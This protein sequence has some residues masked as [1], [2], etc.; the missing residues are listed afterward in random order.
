MTEPQA[1]ERPSRN[2]RSLL[3]PLS[4]FAAM[5]VLCIITIR[6][7]AWFPGPPVD[8]REDQPVLEPSSMDFRPNSFPPGVAGALKDAES[9]VIHLIGFPPE[10]VDALEKD[11]PDSASQDRAHQSSEVTTFHGWP[12]LGSA[13]VTS[14]QT[15]KSIVQSLIRGVEQH[16]DEGPAC[17]LPRHGVRAALRDGG[18]IDLVICFKCQLM[19]VHFSPIAPDHLPVSGGEPRGAQVRTLGDSRLSL[20]QSLQAAEVDL[21][22]E[23]VP[24]LPDP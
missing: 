18:T 23:V 5:A 2:W 7:L 11:P 13:H 8:D 12:I 4:S 17:F 6:V 22:Q 21:E 9:L 15:V 20:N 19:E 1:E 16:R 14:A 24:W 3:S 10:S